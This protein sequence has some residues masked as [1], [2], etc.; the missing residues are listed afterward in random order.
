MN[1]DLIVEAILADQPT[2]D[3][4]GDHSPADPD[5]GS[6]AYDVTLN[7]T[8]PK[9]V[10]SYEGLRY[11]GTGEPALDSQAYGILQRLKNHP[12][13]LLTVYRTVPKNVKGGI[14]PGNWVTTI[15]KY[16]VDHGKANLSNN[17]RIISKLVTARDIFT[18]GD[19][20][21]EW[22]YFPQPF[23]PKSGQT[24]QRTDQVQPRVLD[25]KEV[26]DKVVAECPASKSGLHGVGHWRN[27]EQFGLQLAKET[28]A[29]SKVVALFA[30]FHDCKRENDGQ[31]PDHGPRAAAYIETMKNELGL[32]NSQLSKLIEACRT[33]TSHIKSSDPTVAASMDADRLDL[34]RV[35]HDINPDMLN[36]D[37]ARKIAGSLNIDDVVEEG[38]GRTLGRIG[39]GAALGAALMAGPH[40]P[41]AQKSKPAISLVDDRLIDALVKVESGGNDKAVGDK[42]KALGPLQIHP[43]VVMDYNRWSGTQYRHEDMFNRKVAVTV[44]KKYLD[45]YGRSYWKTTGKKPDA[46]ILARIWNGG[47]AGWYKNETL[48]YMN[49]VRNTM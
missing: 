5:T 18:A 38:L 26:W 16:A 1:F 20:W 6:P 45:V 13:H 44:C 21:L 29:D 41:V 11:Y 27:V 32:D 28:G 7:G 3:H 9:D 12:N 8:Y 33:H 23:V 48:G 47:P 46:L 19:S 25:F 2:D 31:D 42:G 35:G 34:G 10:Y 30:L 14:K 37:A 15:R 24:R 4:R 17:Y 49:K 43:E 36:T 22:G 39:A 40:Q